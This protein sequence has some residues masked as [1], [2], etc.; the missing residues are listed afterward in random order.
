V[1]ID[2]PHVTNRAQLLGELRRVL[3]PGGR[4][5]GAFSIHYQ[6][7]T[8]ETFVGEL[9]DS[10]FVLERLIE[11]RPTPALRDVDEVVYAK[12]QQAPSFLAARLRR[13]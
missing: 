7:M 2:A 11:P 13:P 12:L 6:R 3:R 4:L 10:G 8:L 1:R 5:G 9:L